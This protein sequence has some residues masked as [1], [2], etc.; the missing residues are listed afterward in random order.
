MCF[1]ILKKCRKWWPYDFLKAY[2]SM[3]LHSTICYLWHDHVW[4]WDIQIW[5]WIYRTLYTFLLFIIHVHLYVGKCNLYATCSVEMSILKVTMLVFEL[6]HM[7]YDMWAML[8]VLANKYQYIAML[9]ASYMGYN[10]I[11]LDTSWWLFVHFEG[12]KHHRT[13]NHCGPT[14]SRAK[15]LFCVVDLTLHF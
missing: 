10:T 2:K 4:S 5:N 9:H 11:S 6:I 13:I 3:S 7:I 15:Y 8:F 14:I 1:Y 12:A